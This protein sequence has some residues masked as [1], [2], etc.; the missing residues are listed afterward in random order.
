MVYA[1]TL[2]YAGA[3]PFRPEEERDDLTANEVELLTQ[4]DTYQRL[5]EARYLLDRLEDDV[6]GVSPAVKQHVH[7]EIIGMS[8]PQHDIDRAI[9]VYVDEWLVDHRDGEGQ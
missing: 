1:H 6:K 3:E 9:D 2:K 8:R 7:G 5:A 4:D